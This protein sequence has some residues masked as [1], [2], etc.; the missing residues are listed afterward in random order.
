MKK[1]LAIVLALAMVFA[2]A[3]CGG[4]GDPGKKDP[5][6]EPEK[7]AFKIG[8]MQFGEFTALQNAFE[9]FRQGLKEA[10]WTEG[11]DFEIKY[12]SAA[13]DTAN[14]PTIADT[15]IN[16]GSD[17]I[18]A[19]ATPSVSCIKEKTTSI[20]VVFTAVTD[21]VASKLVAS[22]EKPGAN[23]T[24]TSDMNPV[25]EQIDLLKEMLPEAKK[26]AVFYCSSESNSQ[27]QFVLAKAQIE[28]LGMECVQ[29]TIAAVDEIKSA[30]ESLKGA[31]D[32]IYI[33]TDNTLA[34]SMALVS[35]VAN[36]CGLPIVGGEPG[37]VEAGATATFGIDY[38]ELGKTSAKM[39]VE[40]LKSADPL[41]AA[42]AMPVA[43]QT[44]GCVTVLNKASVE[45]LGLKV[46][47]SITDRA[48]FY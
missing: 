14:C 7:K 26:V 32:A 37:Q 27:A 36:E 29:K 46:P 20:P 15:L 35:S 9:G 8:V 21:P 10:G 4:S 23:I 41:A 19:I 18:F 39:A 3:A 48:E 5:E 44:K 22:N 13:A 47:A 24:G 38:V 43:F 42:A 34:D 33:P 17:L 30:V 45:A 28:K 16:D 1:L 31:V 11:K 12:L 2:F 25:A 6:K 40:I